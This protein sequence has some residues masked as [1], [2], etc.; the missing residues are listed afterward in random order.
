MIHFGINLCQNSSLLPCLP[1]C[2]SCSSFL[3]ELW[4]VGEKRASPKM[5]IQS[6]PAVF[7]FSNIQGKVPPGLLSVL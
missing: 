4:W 5:Q 2:K 7:A 6:G 1:G 3:C